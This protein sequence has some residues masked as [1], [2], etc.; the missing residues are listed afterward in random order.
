MFSTIA[1]FGGFLVPFLLDKFGETHV[2]SISIISMLVS[3]M[4]WTLPASLNKPLP[5]S[6]EEAETMTDPENSKCCVTL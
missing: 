3:Q 1:G 5:N 2:I 6:I 4:I